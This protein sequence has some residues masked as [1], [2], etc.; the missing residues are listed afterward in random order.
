M[1]ISKLLSP[2]LFLGLVLTVIN[3]TD[4]N[5][6]DAPVLPPPAVEGFTATEGNGLVTLNWTK[7]DPKFVTNYELKYTPGDG[8]PINIPN[9]ETSY[10]VNGLVND[11]EYTFTLVAQKTIQT[12]T[13]S[14]EKVSIT[15]TPFEP[16][17]A[18]PEITSF[19]FLAASNPDMALETEDRVDLTG[20]IDLE[21]NT[22]TF[23]EA[24]VSAYVY[25]DKLVATFEVEAG[26][27]V[28][29]GGADQTSGT[30]VQDFTSSVEYV[31]TKDGKT[32]TFI[33]TVNKNFFATI[34]DDNLR[35]FL[36]SEGLPFNADNQLESNATAVIEYKSG[37]KI[38]ID[39]VGIANVKGIE[40]FVTAKEI[41]AERNSFPSI[42]ISRNAGVKNILI[43]LNANIDNIEIGDKTDLEIIYMNDAINLTEMV[44]QP[45]IDANSGLKRFYAQ[46]VGTGLASINVDNLT[47]MERL[48]LNES[49]A[50]ASAASINTMLSKNPP[51]ASD[52][53]NLRVYKD[54]DGSQCGSYD[55]STYQC[56]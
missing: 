45:I 13:Q 40:F 41:D 35:S 7:G 21:N 20:T 46:G 8:E 56:N 25:R 49:T 34:P 19:K 30:T 54:S 18:G 9:T 28:A 5:I 32:R 51:I 44:M 3:C 1:K 26:A 31:V 6:I 53:G 50:M 55:A 2:F 33:V 4:E 39:N 52:L 27:T 24:D 38:N 37:A 29:I 22:I 36:I 12:T 47:A 10:T 14:S 48:R 11:T 15:A 42:N 17:T 23:S 16:D 43:G